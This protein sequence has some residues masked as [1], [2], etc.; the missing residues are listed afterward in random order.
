M[1]ESK[2]LCTYELF[3]SIPTLDGSKTVTQEIF[4][5]NETIKT[6]SKSRLV[7]RGQRI[8][9]PEFGLSERHILDL[10]RLTAEPEGML[11]RNTIAD[12]FDSSF[13]QDEFLVDVVHD[14]CIPAMA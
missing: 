2:Y 6:Y 1:I 14:V 8:D 3:S 5:W 4:E 9:G 10:E 11:G 13:F 12:E 7:R